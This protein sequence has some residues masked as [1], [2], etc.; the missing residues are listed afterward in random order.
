MAN[1]RTGAFRACVSHGPIEAATVIRRERA[2]SIGARKILKFHIRGRIY[3]CSHDL[4]CLK[5]KHLL[6]TGGAHI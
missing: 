2:D 3:V 4:R 6:Q 5:T 1:S